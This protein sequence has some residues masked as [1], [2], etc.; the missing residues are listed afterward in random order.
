MNTPKRH[1]YV[2]EF[3]FAPWTNSQDNKMYVYKRVY[4]GKIDIQRIA[5]KTAAYEDNIYNL[6]DVTKVMQTQLETNFFTPCIDTPASEIMKKIINNG[7]ND[8]NTKERS[9]FTRFL[10]SIRLRTPEIS[11]HLCNQIPKKI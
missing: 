6:R 1:H 3:Y 2:P 10:M 4:E 11:R 5:T 9:I 7:I 8:L